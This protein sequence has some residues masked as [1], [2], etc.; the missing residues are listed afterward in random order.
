MPKLGK[1]LLRHN[2]SLKNHLALWTTLLGHGHALSVLGGAIFQAPAKPS[3][4]SS[5]FNHNAVHSFLCIVWI[6]LT[7]SVPTCP[8]F[9]RV[10]GNEMVTRKDK[11]GLT[12]HV[13]LSYSV[14]FASV[15]CQARRGREQLWCSELRCSGSDGPEEAVEIRKALAEATGA[16]VVM[17]HR[18]R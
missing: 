8:N 5:H 9:H 6:C 17:A 16:T 7:S 1:L 11:K 14:D 3:V 2:N 18:Y 4:L 12:T 10:N 15:M 13:L